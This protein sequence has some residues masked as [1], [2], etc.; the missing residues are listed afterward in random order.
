MTRL[1]YHSVITALGAGVVM[2]I[3]VGACASAEI[4][5]AE[6]VGSIQSTRIANICETVMGLSPSDRPL[7]G[8]WLGNPGSSVGRQPLPDMRHQPHRFASPSPVHCRDQTS[9]R[10]LSR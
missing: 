8:V 10:C 2:C 4:S 5:G 3:T 7:S 1:S 6:P 9:G